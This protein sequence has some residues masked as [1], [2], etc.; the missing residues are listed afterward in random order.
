MRVLFFSLKFLRLI[1]NIF[2]V[3][4]YRNFQDLSK[5]ITKLCI[6]LKTDYSSNNS[7]N[8]V[9]DDEDEQ[10]YD[11]AVTPGSNEILVHEKIVE[12][13][14]RNRNQNIRSSSLIALCGT[15]HYK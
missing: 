11:A 5:N 3:F 2:F 4:C 14:L 12:N 6:Q 10:W 13:F 15:L 1:R 7:T 8:K 9:L